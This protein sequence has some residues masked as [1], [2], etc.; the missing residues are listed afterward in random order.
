MAPEVFEKQAHVSAYEKPVDMW[1]CGMLMFVLLAG[2]YAFGL[3]KV[4][5]FDEIL[6][7][8]NLSDLLFEESAFREVPDE[9]RDLIRKMLNKDA[10]ARITAQASLEHPFF[11]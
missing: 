10:A 3:D 1:A 6:R 2:H 8:I 4:S 11:N 7:T 5:D 9:A